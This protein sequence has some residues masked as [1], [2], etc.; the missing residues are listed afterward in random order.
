MSF[1][2]SYVINIVVSK[3]LVT[4]YTNSQ[5]KSKSGQNEIEKPIAGPILI[6]Y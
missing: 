4:N 1:P 6:L 2:S 5:R 3:H